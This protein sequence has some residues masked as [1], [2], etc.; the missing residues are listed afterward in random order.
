MLSSTRWRRALP[1][2]VQ[3]EKRKPKVGLNDG[4]FSRLS[5]PACVFFFRSLHKP[6]QL[7]RAK[8]EGFWGQI[9]PTTE[10]EN[11]SERSLAEKASDTLLPAHS[12][13]VEETPQTPTSVSHLF[14]PFSFSHGG[15]N[16]LIGCH[17]PT[18]VTAFTPNIRGAASC[19]LASLNHPAPTR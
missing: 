14:F 1:S 4:T 15:V 19:T 16:P 2:A 9:A 12:G 17:L 11:I 13:S 10:E 8:A 18:A 6:G 7:F 3:E 5:A